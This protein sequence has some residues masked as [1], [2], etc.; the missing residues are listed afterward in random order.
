VLRTTKTQVVREI[1][2]FRPPVPFVPHIA[3]RDVTDLIDNFTVPKGA[4]IFPDIIAASQQGFTQPERFDPDRFSADRSEHIKFADNFMIFGCGPHLCLGRQY[5]MNQLC[6]FVGLAATLLDFDRKST[7]DMDEIKYMPT[8]VPKDDCPV[9]FR[10][11]AAA[12][13]A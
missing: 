10:T 11:R 2:R 1:L 6:V 7:P 3:E 13:S 9:Q 12:A 5:A 4:I 8:V